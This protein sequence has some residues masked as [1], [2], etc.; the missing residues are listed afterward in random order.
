[1]GETLENYIRL[2]NLSNPQPIAETFTSTI[3]RVQ[4]SGQYCVLKILSEAGREDEGAAADVL[5]WYD[6]HGAVRLLQHDAGAV[7]LE[8]LDGGDVTELV[9]A[10]KDDAATEIIAGVLNKLHS[11]CRF[12]SPT[13]LT[14]LS[15]RFGSLFDSAARDHEQAVR[16]LLVRGAAVAHGLLGRQGRPHV[17]HG[18]I[19]HE[20]IRQHTRRGWLAID[21]KGLVGDRIYDAAN[22]LCNP[23]SLPKIVLDRNRLMR[24]ADIMATILRVS[25]PRLL[26]YVFAHACLSACWSMED[27]HDPSLALAIAR[28]AETCIAP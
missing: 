13:N 26:S 9:K 17:L 25:Q 14:P 2:W 4:T 8:Y 16:R 10:G 21:P 23:H 22:T 19:H 6:G 11:V 27:G 5:K 7:L 20:N 12:A 1:M 18:D 28:I 3:F 24:Q 15:R